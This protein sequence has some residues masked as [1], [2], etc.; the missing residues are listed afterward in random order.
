MISLGAGDA[1]IENRWPLIELRMSRNDCLAWME[2]NGYPKPS[3]SSCIGCPYHDDRQ[4]REIRDADP[5]S[6]ADAV[7]IDRRM[8]ENGPQRGMTNLEYMHRSCVPLDL[9]DLSTLEDHGQI[10]FLDE[11]DGMC[12]V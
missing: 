1:Y 8:R 5:V 10:S 4:W 3:K 9:V 12:G 7:E 2:R 11:C 6:W